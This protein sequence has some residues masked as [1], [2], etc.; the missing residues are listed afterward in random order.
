[1]AEIRAALPT[2]ATEFPGSIPR[3]KQDYRRA[4]R[5]DFWHE[6]GGNNGMFKVTIGRD[7]TM[8]GVKVGKGNGSKYLGR[9]C[10]L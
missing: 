5:N 2:P 7:A 1:M 6:R 9:I 10:W 3:R 8:H 4:A